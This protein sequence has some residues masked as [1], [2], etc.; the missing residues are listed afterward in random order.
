MESLP[1]RE[2]VAVI[3]DWENVRYTVFNGYYE[4][5]G[6]LQK[7]EEEIYKEAE[8]LV[9]YFR[10]LLQDPYGDDLFRIYFYTARPF[11][12]V[13]GNKDY[14]KEYYFQKVNTFISAIGEQSD[15]LLRLG[16]LLPRGNSFEQ[17]GVDVQIG[18]DIATLSLKRYVDT[19]IIFS[20]D[21]DL[22][23]ALDFARNNGIRV[24]IVIPQ[25]PLIIKERGDKTLESLERGKEI[26]SSLRKLYLHADFKVN[27]ELNKFLRR[28]V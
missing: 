3:V 6:I 17:K 25:D 16:E 8:K 22:I 2:K 1:S 13:I 20:F 4:Q 14:S 28:R 12:G 26:L 9:S 19:I 27:F 10:R 11:G 24:G 5:R 18:L 15:V 23:P 21:T 7:E